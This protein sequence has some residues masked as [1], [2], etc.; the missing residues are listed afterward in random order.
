MG[1]MKCYLKFYI[2]VKSS[3]DQEDL[4]KP[5]KANLITLGELNRMFSNHSAFGPQNETNISV[6]SQR[7]TASVFNPKPVFVHKKETV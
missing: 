6:R 4:S 5:I 7:D 2:L 3:T 1:I